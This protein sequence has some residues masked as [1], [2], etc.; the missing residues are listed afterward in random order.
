MRIIKML[1]LC[2]LHKN[3]GKMKSTINFTITDSTRW[4]NPIITDYSNSGPEPLF[5][6]PKTREIHQKQRI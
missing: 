5:L 6:C 2:E 1:N 3:D 4:Y